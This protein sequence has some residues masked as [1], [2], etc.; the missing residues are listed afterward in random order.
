MLVRGGEHLALIGDTG[1]EVAGDA[2]RLVEDVGGVERREHFFSSL[3]EEGEPTLEVDGVER[4]LEMHHHGV[5]AVTSGAEHGGG[6]EVLEL[7]E[8]VGPVA[9]DGVEDGADLVV[10]ADFGVEAVDEGADLF[11][12]DV[13]GV[14]GPSLM[15]GRAGDYDQSLKQDVCSHRTTTLA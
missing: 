11:F 12:G 10:L 6:P 13:S 3:F 2:V 8:V 4:K 5:A 9:D 1:L 14:H 7:G 15:G